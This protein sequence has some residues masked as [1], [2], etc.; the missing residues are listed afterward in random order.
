V[1]LTERG[2]A[3]SS[4]E[5]P[6]ERPGFLKAFQALRHVK[7]RW[8]WLSGLGMTG[9]QGFQQLSMAWLVLDLTGS[10]GQLGLVV[11]FQGV[12][13]S[14]ASFYGGVLADRY[15]RRKLLMAAQTFTMCN[16]LA[17]AALTVADVVAI[18]Q[19][20]LSS[21]G[22]GLMQAVTMPARSALV[23]S[24]VGD[25]D[26]VNAVA[27][28]AVQMH[29]SRIIWPSLA[30]GMIALAGAGPTL[31]MSSIG[32][33]FGIFC[34]AMIG[35][36]P[37][38][39]KRPGRTSQAAEMKEGV[40]YAFSEP[41]VSTIMWLCIVAG[42]FGLAYMNLAPAFAREE[43]GLGAGGVGLFM[44]S[45]GIGA[46]FGSVW[47]LAFPIKDGQRTFTLLMFVFAI[48]VLL[49]CLIHNT[50]V[51][52][53]MMGI[54]GMIG[55][56]AVVAGQTLLQTTVPQRLLGRVIGL[57]SL[58]GGLGF[59]TALPI[60]MLGD[61]YGLRWALSGMSVLLFIG[62]LW[63]GVIVPKPPRTVVE[64]APVTT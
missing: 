49:M 60:G 59:V 53:L 38:E 56:V 61:E 5:E 12:P 35:T 15:D 50:A 40:R 4:S 41:G 31:A 58:A 22:L 42:L 51:A 37:Q 63:F 14:L 21:I 36:L 1:A 26:M 3:A 18:W 33:M 11:F 27:L 64:A 30:G 25:K 34:L 29:S 28:N 54:W 44:M 39:E 7:Y 47:L 16:L 62:T 23:R 10:V 45:S 20:Y 48:V 8:Y 55:A 52:F 32:S 6:E 2:R 9:A 24:L 43:L 57:W 19:V 46:I 13:M 17:L